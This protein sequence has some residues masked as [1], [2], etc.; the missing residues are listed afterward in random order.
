MAIY[1]IGDLHLSF[2]SEKPMDIFGEGWV[3][4]HIKVKEHWDQNVQPEDTILITG[5]TSWGLK[6]EDAIEDIKWLQGLSGRKILV[7]GNHDFWWQSIGKMEK[8]FPDICFL[9]NNHYV[10]EDYVICGTRGWMLP[11][12]YNF[13]KDDLKIYERELLRL[14]LSLDSAKNETDKKIMVMMHYP[15]INNENLDSEFVKIFKEYGV[16]T[17]VYAHLHG[18]ES[19]KTSIRGDYD[20]IKYSLTACDYLDCKLDKIIL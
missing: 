13:K 9:Q 16:E 20:G 12:D 18:K 1:A 14:R 6:L 15:P 19:H 3:D 10:Y 2:G 5:D 7:K 8:M 4:H 17:V 11:N